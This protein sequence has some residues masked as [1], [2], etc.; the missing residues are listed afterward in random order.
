MELDKIIS[1]DSAVVL[2]SFPPDCIDLSIQS[3]PYDNLRTYES[4]A[5][6][7]F[8][9]IA[10][11]LFRVTKQGGVCVWVVNDAVVNGSETGT[12]FRQV[13]YFMQCGFN[14]H[15]TMIYKTDKPPVNDNRYQPEFEF[16]FVFSKGAPKTFNPIEIKSLLGGS[17]NTSSSNRQV[18]GSLKPRKNEIVKEY[19]RKGNIWHLGAGFNKTTKDKLAYEH[20]AMFPEQLANDHILSWSNEGDVVLDCFAGSGTTLKMAKILSRHYIGI[21]RVPKYVS[22]AEKRLLATNVPLFGQGRGLT[23]PAPDGGD[24]SAPQALSTPDMFSAIEHEPTPAP[25]R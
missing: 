12:S 2:Q 18:D 17:V 22:L 7:D 16:M 14:L 21:E 19:K 4:S 11:E 1:G 6:F 13:L 9:T 15:D 20:P 3:P 23:L 24:S 10:K 8:E 5:D 25:R